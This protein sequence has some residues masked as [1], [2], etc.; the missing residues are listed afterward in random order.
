MV[1]LTSIDFYFKKLREI[2]VVIDACLDNS[3]TNPNMEA[4]P[5]LKKI[6]SILYETEDIF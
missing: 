4:E 2:E 5:I 6:Q 1:V 3:P